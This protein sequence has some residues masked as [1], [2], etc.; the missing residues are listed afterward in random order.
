[1]AV[2]MSGYVTAVTDDSDQNRRRQDILIQ[3][4]QSIDGGRNWHALRPSPGEPADADK[5]WNALSLPF[6]VGA[7]GRIG[8]LRANAV[9][10]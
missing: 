7:D 8:K 6:A 4:C 2:E 1:M 9:K 5:N 3:R 10:P